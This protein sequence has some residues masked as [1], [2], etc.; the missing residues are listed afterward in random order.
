M[1]YFL[2]C[3]ATGSVKIGYTRGAVADRIDDILPCSPL[4]LELVATVEGSARLEAALHAEFDALRLHN[5]WFRLEGELRVLVRRIIVDGEDAVAPFFAA[6]LARDAAHGTVSAYVGRRC[7]CG[8]C[9][10]AWRADQNARRAGVFRWKP[11]RRG[12]PPKNSATE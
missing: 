9:T 12:R 6:L 10:E 8:A 11:G 2:A 7:R 1:I 5:E 4:P 3:A